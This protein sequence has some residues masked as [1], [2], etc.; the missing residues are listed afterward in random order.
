MFINPPPRRMNARVHLVSAL[1]LALIL[2]APATAQ[3]IS[4]PAHNGATFAPLGLPQPNR[5]RTASG[6]PG[7]DYWQQRADYRIEAT[8][9]P[10]TH[11]LTGTETIT[12]TNNSPHNLDYL[13]LQ[14]DQNLFASDSRDCGGFLLGGIK[15]LQNQCSLFVLGAGVEVVGR[16]VELPHSPLVRGSLSVVCCWLDT[17]DA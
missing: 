5:V 17:T 16:K 2:A 4:A 8:L 6:E 13:W 9:D 10:A 11:R 1:L 14:L 3:Q 15:P 7:P 12:Y